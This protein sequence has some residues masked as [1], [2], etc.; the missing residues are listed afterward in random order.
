MVGWV[1]RN[2]QRGN[3]FH[4]GE[5]FCGRQTG[6]GQAVPGQEKDPELERHQKTDGAVRFRGG[7]HHAAPAGT[8]LDH[9]DIQFGG[10]NQTA[11]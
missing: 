2:D 11:G 8:G 3:A 5:P 10:G 4:R 9:Q 1:F 6:E 7:Q